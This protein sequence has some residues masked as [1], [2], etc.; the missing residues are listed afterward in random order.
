MKRF[1]GF[2]RGLRF[3]LRQRY[4]ADKIEVNLDLLVIL[5]AVDL[6]ALIDDHLVDELIE[7]GRG[8]LGKVR[9]AVYQLH[10]T[11]NID[12]FFLFCVHLLHQLGAALFKLRL[13]RFILCGEL[14]VPLFRQASEGVILIE[15]LQQRVQLV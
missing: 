8:Q 15:L 13:F 1:W 9:I 6:P 7:H 14:C 12:A 5:I 2:Q 10:E 4:L 11:V 3:F